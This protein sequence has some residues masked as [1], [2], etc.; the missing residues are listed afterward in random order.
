[1]SFTCEYRGCLETKKYERKQ[2]KV[3]EIT[4]RIL[5]RKSDCNLTKKASALQLFIYKRNNYCKANKLLTTLQYS[6]D[7]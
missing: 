3:Q 4:R 5:I 2:K 7:C 6:R 1:M